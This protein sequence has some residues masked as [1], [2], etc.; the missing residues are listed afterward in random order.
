MTKIHQ[1][2]VEHQ[3]LWCL[4]GINHTVSNQGVN[5]AFH[6]S[7]VLLWPVTSRMAG[8]YIFARLKYVFY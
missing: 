3:Y 5:C 7:E 1:Q 8:R 2:M 6:N 4:K